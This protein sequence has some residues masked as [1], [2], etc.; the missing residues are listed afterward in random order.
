MCLGINSIASIVK[1]SMEFI[2]NKI[3]LKLF[4]LRYV[5][6]KHDRTL[7]F[8]GGVS[9]KQMILGNSIQNGLLY[10]YM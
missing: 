5:T 10:A 8:Y 1:I 4:N 2:K 9:L 3:F 6:G 7:S